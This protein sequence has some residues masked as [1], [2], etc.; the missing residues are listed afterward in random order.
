[1]LFVISTEPTLKLNVSAVGVKG[2]KRSLGYGLVDVRQISL[3]RLHAKRQSCWLRLHGSNPGEIKVSFALY[4]LR[5]APQ[6][7]G[8]VGSPYQQRPQ[9]LVERSPE[10][11]EGFV[12]EPSSDFIPIGRGSNFYSL[13]I[14]LSGL[15]GLLPLFGERQGQFW[16][17][18]KMFGI[19]IQTECF[20]NLAAPVFM[21]IQ[22]SFKLRSSISELTSFFESLPPVSVYL[23][24]PDLAL[25][26]AT[27]PLRELLI[28]DGQRAPP[29]VNNAE[30]RGGFPLK[31]LFP[32]H[33]ATGMRGLL[34]G[35][36]VLQ[37]EEPSSVQAPSPIRA[38][39]P[40]G[41]PA[42]SFTEGGE[43]AK[44]AG[45][46][47]GPGGSH[48]E[49]GMGAGETSPVAL[50]TSSPP[51]S[52]PR[53]LMSPP[54]D[55]EHEDAG[56]KKMLEVILQR[57]V[58]HASDHDAAPLRKLLNGQSRVRLVLNPGSSQ[59]TY[60]EPIKVTGKTMETT[61]ADQTV[62]LISETPLTVAIPPSRGASRLPGKH[63]PCVVFF[64]AVDVI[65]PC[66]SALQ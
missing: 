6:T 62:S 29:Q 66:A 37:R 56:P 4:G 24:A 7:G 14:T 49:T 9:T 13:S 16:L 22:D 47:I 41:T 53:V 10:T 3:S 48:G 52:A 27:I 1:M 33:A 64:Q 51:S 26:V 23:C 55:P 44:H 18:Y 61:A 65:P 8:N 40:A 46:E 20:K 15:E 2:T 59:L 36:V 42:V 54:A 34:Q 17:S 60:S 12:A 5:E 35:C 28:K 38:P 63:S 57:A 45:A 39:Q 21:P 30:L 32:A 19:V 43:E 58:I 11:N 25:G 31:P 50:P